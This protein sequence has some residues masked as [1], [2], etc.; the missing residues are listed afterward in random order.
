MTR[1]GALRTIGSGFGML[2]LGGILGASELARSP[3][4]VRPTHFAPKAKRV[5]F[6]FLN[7]GPSQV[8]TFD[9]KPML[10][11]YHGQPMPTPNLKTERKTGNLLK[12]PSSSRNSDR[13]ASRSARSFRTWASA[14]TMSA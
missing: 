14:S 9:P 13:A 12:S 7:G 2:G 4:E 1:R 5:I 10:T 11:K 3:L 6:L 8:D